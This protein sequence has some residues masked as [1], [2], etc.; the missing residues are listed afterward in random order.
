MR[1]PPLESWIH[2]DSM[3]SNRVLL[4][5]R[6]RCVNQRKPMNHTS[7]FE[8]DRRQLP[9][10][11]GLLAVG[12]AAV[13]EE[14]CLARIGA[15]RKGFHRCDAVLSQAIRDIG[16][17]IELPVAFAFGRDEELCIGGIGDNKPSLEFRSDFIGRLADAWSDSSTDTLA[18]GSQAYHRS[19]GR[20]GNAG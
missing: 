15:S 5:R 13:G 12:G 6:S 19:H 17:E 9:P 7:I 3:T 10:I 18:L 14:V 16:Q 1:S 4:A 20:F 8:H 2:D 11:I